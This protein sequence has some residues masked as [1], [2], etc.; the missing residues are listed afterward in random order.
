MNMLKTIIIILFMVS[1][2]FPGMGKKE[3]K[4]INKWNHGNKE[5]YSI[6]YGTVINN[7]GNILFR[8]GK[9]MKSVYITPTDVKEFGFL[10]QGPSD[11]YMPLNSCNYLEDIAYYEVTG[12]IKIFTKKDNTYTWKETISLKSPMRTICR[13]FLFYNDKWF[14]AGVI[15]KSWDLSKK[16]NRFFRF[17]AFDNKGEKLKGLLPV[18]AESPFKDGSLEY[19]LSLHKGRI[20]FM[21]ENELKVI[22]I[23]TNKIEVLKENVLDAPSFYIKMPRDFYTQNDAQISQN[24]L[25]MDIEKWKTSYSIITNTAIENGYLAI[26]VRTCSDKLKKYAMLFYN[27][28]TFKLEKTFLI[29][30]FFIGSR[31]GIYYFYA[32]GN[33]GYDENADECIINLYAFTEKK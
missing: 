33:P 16:K 1:S 26:Q 24:K 25:G 27:A 10:G 31:N 9:Q 4:Q 29:D 28:E 20:L 7:K 2:S 23:D 11:L 21:V 13:D 5:I 32:N 3:F 18:E 14:L 30:D 6:I 19:F 8:A 22:S 12:K 15:T 17:Y